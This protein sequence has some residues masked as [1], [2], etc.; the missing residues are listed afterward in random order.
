VTIEGKCTCEDWFY[1]SNVLHCGVAYSVSLGS[2][3]SQRMMGVSPRT[4]HINLPQCHT[5]FGK[6][7]SINIEVASE[8]DYTHIL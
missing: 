7:D 5:L 6:M 3:K 4:R 8:G 1:L 2:N